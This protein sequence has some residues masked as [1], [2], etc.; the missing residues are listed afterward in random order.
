MFVGSGIRQGRGEP[1]PD[2]RGEL[3]N[4]AQ[5]VRAQLRKKEVMSRNPIDHAGRPAASQ[6]YVWRKIVPETRRENND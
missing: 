3:E 6:A 1:D 4:V 2:N 5:Q